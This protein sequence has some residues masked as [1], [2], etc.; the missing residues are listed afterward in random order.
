MP[1][2]IVICSDGTGN[3]F[4]KGVS[5]VTRLIRMLDLDNSQEQI[6]IYDQGIGANRKRL[7]S[8]KEYRRII[9]DQTSLIVLDK[10]WPDLVD[11]F[12]RLAGLLAG[13]GL[14]ENVRAMYRTLT[15]IYE[16][17][18]H[19]L[20]F[21]FSRGAFTVRALAGLLYRCG[22]PPN[23]DE[24]DAYFEEA[25][26]L[27]EP[28]VEDQVRMSIFRC[29]YGPVRDCPIH[30]LGI[31][32][33]VK[34]YGGLRPI[35]LP[36]LRH[37]PIVKTVRHALALDEHRAWFNATTWGQ[38]DGECAKLR[39]KEEHF[40]KYKAQNI[41]EVWFR[42][43]HSDVGGGDEE[44]ET[45]TISLRWMLAEAEAAGLRI[46][47]RGRS[48]LKLDDR[49]GPPEIHESYNWKWWLVEWLPR[50]EID[51]SGMYPTTHLRIGPTGTRVPDKLRRRKH[52]SLHRTV[53]SDTMI[54]PPVRYRPEIT[55]TKSSAPSLP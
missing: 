32:D 25:W 2:K 3:T 23:L 36:H 50:L 45:A 48:L 30:F 16:P 40:P 29:E 20:L 37:N 22:L 54:P 52:V 14:R 38:L 53:G 12:M 18:A 35:I 46:N 34:S 41:D 26:R 43:C 15:E 31:W 7:G 19:V 28:L 24:F 17:A 1:R 13:F 33:T 27:Y 11:P 42:G 9:S 51:N 21:G 6:V 4:D 44:R 8:I 49:T 5:N 47:D 39:L 10:S 55:D